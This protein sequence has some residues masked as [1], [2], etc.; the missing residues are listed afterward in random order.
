MADVSSRL[1]R[2]RER[3]GLQIEDISART[4][5]KP[6]FLRA[7]ESGHFETLPGHFF[8]RA[9]LKTYAREVGLSAD[10][11]VADFDR[12]YGTTPTVELHQLE[13]AVEANE[14]SRAARKRNPVAV[15]ASGW[16]VAATAALALALLALANRDEPIGPTGAV[17]PASV[18][19]SGVAAAPAPVGTSGT[20]ASPESVTIEI[21]PADTIWVAAT[22][23]GAS[24]VYKL[25]Q[26]GQRV[27][28]TGRE[29]SFRIG[30]AAAFVYS[31][32]GAPGK[33]IGGVG[34]VREFQITTDN[35]R[36]YLR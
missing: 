2:A 32:N 7:L 26:P 24:A 16:Q 13:S 5:I 22:A 3:A 36:S 35:Y 4:K 14:S 34:E 20:P 15:S 23:D 11:V 1:L 19:P 12:A 27:K 31:V 25:L 21:E 9:F 30:N 8:T 17:T 33:S 18:A 10:E 29:L 28:V 6:A